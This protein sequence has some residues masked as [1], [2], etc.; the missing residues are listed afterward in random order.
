V[1]TCPEAEKNGSLKYGLAAAHALAMSK[2]PL[3]TVVLRKSF[4]FGGAL[5][6]GY[7]AGQTVSFTWPT[8]AF[9][10]LP[11]D[12]AVEASHAAEIAAS[13]E[14]DKLRQQLLAQYAEHSGPYP[15][16]GQFKTDDVIDPRETR[17]RLA[18]ALEV[19]LSRR[20]ASPTPV[21]KFGVM[22]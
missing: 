11:P 1:V 21:A 20:T 17:E 10:S 5:M 7:R 15:A 8:A 12:A 3:F 4:G 2:S 19:S 6:A 16:A 18:L 22:P 13:S 9:S 14:P